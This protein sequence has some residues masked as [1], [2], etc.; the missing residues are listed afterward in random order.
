MSYEDLLK[1][2]LKKVP[3]KTEKTERFVVPDAVVQKDGARTIVVNFS[4]IVS[5][6]R[7][8]QGHFLKFLLKELATKGEIKGKR[9][10]LLGNFPATQINKKIDLY[11]KKYVICPE[12]GK[13]DTKLKKEGR[14]HVIV[15]EACGAKHKAD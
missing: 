13:P 2:G 3:K 10:T 4:E 6:L 11:V 7:R 9:L 14:E 15:C 8:K 1:R 5:A 12:C